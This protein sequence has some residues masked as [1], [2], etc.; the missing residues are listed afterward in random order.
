MIVLA[1]F[2]TT[3]IMCPQVYGFIGAFFVGG[4]DHRRERPDASSNDNGGPDTSPQIRR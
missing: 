2:F 3:L 4:N 1:A